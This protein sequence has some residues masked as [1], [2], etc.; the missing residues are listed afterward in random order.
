MAT[1]HGFGHSNLKYCI[2]IC[3]HSIFPKLT[4]VMCMNIF[5]LDSFM[6]HSSN[7]GSGL[8][9]FSDFFDAQATV[10]LIV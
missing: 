5:A 9:D 4:V 6:I 3:V 2:Q 7:G 8:F 10:T 1:W